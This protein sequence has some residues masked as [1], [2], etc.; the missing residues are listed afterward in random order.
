MTTMQKNVFQSRWGFHPISR[1]SSKKL[2]FINGKFAKAQHAAGRWERWEHKQPQNRVLMERTSPRAKKTPVLGADGKPVLM[3]EPK[4]NPLFFITQPTQDK[5][6][7]QILG[8]A[9]STG[10]GE[11]ILM[12][13]RIARTPAAT[14][15][16]VKELPITEEEIDKL[17]Q[18]LND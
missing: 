11:K 17:Y 10:L 18:L 13:S 2:R 6:W 12:C 14:P 7:Y 3:S 8:R 5:G 15:E 9:K 1:E 4:V 16:D